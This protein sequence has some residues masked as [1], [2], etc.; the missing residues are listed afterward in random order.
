MPVRTPVRIG[1]AIVPPYL[2][3]LADDGKVEGLSVDFLR[4]IEAQ[5]ETPFRIY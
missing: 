4:E 5:L 1:L 2:T 3:V